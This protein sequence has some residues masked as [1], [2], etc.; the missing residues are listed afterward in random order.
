MSD[1]K[2]RISD[3][4]RAIGPVAPAPYPCLTLCV[5][6]SYTASETSDES[7]CAVGFIA[8]SD[9]SLNVVDCVAGRWK[10]LS[11]PDKIVSVV[12]EW[13]DI[14]HLKIEYSP[15]VDLLIDTISLRAD[16]QE[17]NLPRITVFRSIRPKRDRI[18]RL[19]ELLNVGALKIRNAPFAYKILE[20]AE[21]FAY[22]RPDN[23]RRLDSRLDSISMLANYH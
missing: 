4:R 23:R 3:W 13:R 8:E 12:D 11:L 18:W 22:D 17:V 21:K 7:A 5:D 9:S 19:Q 15:F 14:R 20:E 6:T 1:F 10:G 2:F 16:M